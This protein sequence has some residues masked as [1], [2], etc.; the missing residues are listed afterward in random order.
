MEY[1]LSLCECPYSISFK[2]SQSRSVS[3]F[4][5]SFTI[6]SNRVTGLSAD[7]LVDCFFECFK[8]R[9]SKRCDC[10]GSWLCP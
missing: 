10:S 3:E 1:G 8:T 9:N 5:H 6:S 2:L 7:A 4:Y